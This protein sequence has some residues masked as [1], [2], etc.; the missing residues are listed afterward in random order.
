MLL[1]RTPSFLSR[2]Q[3]P[4]SE[5][6]IVGERLR[7]LV[8]RAVGWRILGLVRKEINVS[9]RMVVCIDRNLMLN[10]LFEGENY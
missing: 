1:P 7:G 6:R 2:S 4:R 10:N 8:V 9:S 3:R 5:T